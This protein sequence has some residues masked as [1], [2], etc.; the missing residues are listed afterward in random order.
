ME[1]LKKLLEFTPDQALEAIRRKVIDNKDAS[2]IALFSLITCVFCYFYEMIEGYGCPDAVAE[3]VYYYVGQKNAYSLARWL[4]PFLNK[5]LGSNVVIPFIIILVYCVLIAVAIYLL[6]RE[7]RIT[8]P[9]Q[10]IL[11]AGLSISFPVVIRQYAYLYMATSYAFS[12]LASVLAVLCFRKNTLWGY[13]K[14]TVCVVLMLGAYQSNVASVATLALIFLASD[15]CQGKKPKEIAKWFAATVLCGGLA[16]VINLGIANVMAGLA[17]VPAAEKVSSFSIKEIVK[18]LYF[19]IPWSARWFFAYFKSEVFARNAVYLVLFLVLLAETLCMA[20]V[21]FREKK[22]IRAIALILCVAAEPFLMNL[23]VILFPHNGIIDY[24]RYHYVLFFVQIVAWHGFL[25]GKLAGNL[26]RWI[27]S[28]CIL[29]L[30]STYVIS[31]NS[32]AFLY[33]LEYESCHDQ[34]VQ[35]LSEIHHLE[36]YDPEETKIVLGSAIL[37]QDTSAAFGPLLRYAVMD[38]GP[39]FWN[40]LHGMT[41]CRYWYFLD[42]LGVNPKWI[43]STEYLHVISTE[44]YAEMPAWPKEGSVRMIDGY[45]VIKTLE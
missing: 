6:C 21:L 16:S 35:M 22:W 45:A 27:V 15:V 28:L 8:S 20:W 23:C 39:I 3:G 26:V 14:G 43:D 37:Y 33:R 34:A 4:I 32:T 11:L 36:G 13:V 44:E 25:R 18:F 24:M 42:Y 7:F 10:Q 5:V 38:G 29:Y 31:A 1:K 40:D 17:D 2:R 19:T 9:S 12:F 30:V 41:T